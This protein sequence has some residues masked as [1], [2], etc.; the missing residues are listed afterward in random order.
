MRRSL[1]SFGTVVPMIAM[2]L[3]L[4]WFLVG[5]TLGTA[6]SKMQLPQGLFACTVLLFFLG[7]TARLSWQLCFASADDYQLSFWSYRGSDCIAL[8]NIKLVTAVSKSRWPRIEVTF[9]SPTRLGTKVAII[10]PFGFSGKR[11]WEVYEFLAA[12]AKEARHDAEIISGRRV[13][14]TKQNPV[15]IVVWLAIVLV[16]L[17]LFFSA[18][19]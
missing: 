13:S 14:S 4:T 19:H 9:S 5:T 7:I 3:L 11:Y 10:P 17:A 12:S 16:V 18:R 1:S 6:H 15:V 2:P 8:S